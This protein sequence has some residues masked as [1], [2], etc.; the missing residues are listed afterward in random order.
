MRCYFQLRGVERDHAAAA[1]FVFVGLDPNTGWLDG[2]LGGWEW[3]GTGR[4]QWREFEFDGILHNIKAAPTANRPFNI[5]Q[6]VN[7]DT[8]RTFP[9]PEIMI[10]V[11]CDVHGWMSAWVGVLDHP[12]F[13]STAPDGRVVLGNLPPGTYNAQVTGSAPGTGTG[14]HDSSGQG[15]G[16]H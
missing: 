4:V 7:M 3:S 12:Y 1:A 8:Q 10:P 13:G 14:T 6:P 9:T 5:S 16:A 11:Q 2:A 15:N